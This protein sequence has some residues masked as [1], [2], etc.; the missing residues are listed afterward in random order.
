VFIFLFQSSP[1]GDKSSVNLRGEFHVENVTTFDDTSADNTEEVKEDRM[2]IDTE[3]TT[4]KTVVAKAEEVAVERANDGAVVAAAVPPQASKAV[5]LA[6][7]TSKGTPDKIDFAALYPRFWSLQQM[8]SNPTKAFVQEDLAEFRSNLELTVQSFAAISKPEETRQ[9]D[10]N[11]K[12]LK[13]T[14]SRE[15]EELASSFNPKY[16]TNKDLFELEVSSLLPNNILRA[17]LTQL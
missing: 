4:E 8:F 10:S 13:R 9:G 2:E 3:P 5:T 7:D 1:L 16:L 6:S 14:R 11:K 15:P 12:D 17:R